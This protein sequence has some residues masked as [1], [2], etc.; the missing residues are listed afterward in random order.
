MLNVQCIVFCQNLLKLFVII[1][2]LLNA[3]YQL[4][5]SRYYL[6]VIYLFCLSGF[7]YHIYFIFYQLL[8]EELIYHVYCAIESSIKIPEVVFCF[9]IN[10]KRIDK[11]YK[12]TENYLNEL[13]KEIIIE[14]VFKNITYLSRS[15]EWISLDLNFRDSI[16]KTDTF[17]F[18]NK[19]CLKISL[20]IRI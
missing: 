10:Q 1:Y 16:L 6:F 5:N 17:Y 9:D 18:L 13:T 20:E 2:C 15:N 8:N 19:K 14:K 11:N 3:K 7:T 4:R 12:L